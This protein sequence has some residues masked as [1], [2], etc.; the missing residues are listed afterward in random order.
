MARP[1]AALQAARDM[2]MFRK[3]DGA[4]IGRPPEDRLTFVVPGKDAMTVRFQQP[5]RLKIAADGKQPVWRRM[6]DGGKAEIARISAQPD[7]G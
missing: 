7:H 6:L 4:R 3:E 5:F 1:K 2:K